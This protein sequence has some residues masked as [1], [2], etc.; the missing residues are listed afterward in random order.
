MSTILLHAKDISHSFDIELYS[1]VDLILKSSH[2]AAIV[3]RS[4]SGKS[5][6]LHHCSTFLK[7]SKGQVLLFDQDIYTDKNVDIEDLRRHELG[8]V[9]QFHYLFKGMSALENIEVAT[10]LSGETI[11]EELLRQLEIDTLM[12]Q[13]ISE[14]SGG[15]QQRVSIARVLSKK[16]K[17]IFADEPTGN[18]D[19]E[20]ASLVTGVL[21]NYIQEQD[22]GLLLVTH[23][24]EVASR[25]DES[26]RLEDQKLESI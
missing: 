14:L 20:T 2:S 24:E 21:L 6:L 18:L 22:A 7:P 12:D 9:F 1:H 3:G 5:T 4:G 23:D 13:K 25:C 19:K 17:I 15:Q 26:Y 16:P 8:I 11:D 10:M